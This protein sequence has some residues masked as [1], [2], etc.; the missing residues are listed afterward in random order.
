[1]VQL[2]FQYACQNEPVWL[3]YEASPVY[4]RAREKITGFGSFCPLYNWVRK[5]AGQNAI[6][7]L[8]LFFC[9]P[10]FIGTICNFIIVSLIYNIISHP[11]SW[12]PTQNSLFWVL[13]LQP[14]FPSVNSDFTAR[15]LI[16]AFSLKC[17]WFKH[18]L[19][20]ETISG[21]P[22]PAVVSI[23]KDTE[24]YQTAGATRCL[25]IKLVEYIFSINPG[26]KNV[27]IVKAVSF[28]WS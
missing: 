27:S 1:M 2:P 12:W 10:T 25:I 18:F 22:C 21:I 23:L 17:W 3:S 26:S 19:H 4:S 6:F 9:I 28:L 5:L 8:N 14:A 24:G 15:F 13:S 16:F 7:K 11:H 20:R